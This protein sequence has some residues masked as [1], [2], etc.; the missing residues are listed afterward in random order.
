MNTININDYI[1]ANDNVSS[2]KLFRTELLKVSTNELGEEIF[3]Y[4][5]ENDVLLG[6]RLLVLEKMFGYESSLAN[7]PPNITDADLTNTL[8]D[9]IPTLDADLGISTTS[10]LEKSK[11][12]IGL[13]GVGLDGAMDNIGSVKDV[14][15]K[16]KGFN[17]IE[18]M[19]PF[20]MIDVTDAQNDAEGTYYMKKTTEK[21]HKYYLKTCVS[22]PVI[23][24]YYDDGTPVEGDAHTSSRKIGVHTCIE[25]RFVIDT[26]DLR[27]YF[28][29]IGMNKLCRINSLCLYAGQLVE[30]DGRKDYEH[31]IGTNKYNF[32][33]EMF[34]SDSK[35]LIFIYRIFTS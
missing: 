1:S 19:I 11:R 7:L 6:G 24:A 12:F 23:K 20:R 3:T 15:I 10:V 32:D 34:N 27:E 8:L 30:K 9:N 35:E 17:N 26:K 31:V 33:N 29:S 25:M 4:W 21:Y 5:G 18:D 22:M 13:F 16:S 2:S 28:D 14:D